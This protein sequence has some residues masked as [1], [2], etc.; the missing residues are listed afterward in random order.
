MTDRPNLSVI[1]GLSWEENW[2]MPN[3]TSS[4]VVPFPRT[5]PMNIVFHGDDKF[6]YGHFGV[7]LGQMDCL[8]F[9]GHPQQVISASF[10]DCRKSSPTARAALRVEFTP[11]SR[12][13]LNIPPGV[14]HDFTGLE[15]VTTLNN[16]RLFLPDPDDWVSGRTRWDAGADVINVAS[17]VDPNDAELFD[18]NVNPASDVYYAIVAERQQ[19]ALRSSPLMYPYTH[20]HTDSDGTTYLLKVRERTSTSTLVRD[21]LEPIGKISG[22][23]WA[24]NPFLSSGPKSGFVPLLGKRP[25]YIVDHGFTQEYTHDAYGIHL[26]QRDRL[27][28][29]GAEN[30]EAFVEFVDCRRGSPTLHE[31]IKVSFRPDPL[32][33]LVIPNGVAHRFERMEGI[34]TLNQ[35]EIFLDEAGEYEPGNDVIDWPLSHR[36]FPVLS[37]NSIPASP[38]FYVDLMTSQ[39]ALRAEGTIRS[40]PVV[41]LAKDEQGRDVRVALRRAN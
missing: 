29:V 10:I 1:A 4:F 32:R 30:K 21:F 27:V 26:G 2:R 11:S 34:F 35:G 22:L 25:Y 19:D 20:E 39:N 15:N 23:H 3:G 16:Y 40:T 38:A 28:F 8:T 33:T 7:H 17:D 24:A 18:V 9:L 36:P 12:W 31:S 37:P 41:L 6:E 14:A 5:R 13:A